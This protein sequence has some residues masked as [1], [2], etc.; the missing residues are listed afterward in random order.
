MGVFACVMFLCLLEIET[1]HI[2]SVSFAPVL[3]LTQD[4]DL[5]AKVQKS[6]RIQQ[7]T[8]IGTGAVMPATMISSNTHFKSKLLPAPVQV[9]DLDACQEQSGY[10]FSPTT[11][12]SRYV[13]SLTCVCMHQR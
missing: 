11:S 12:S 9:E 7:D 1:D 10:A 6:W 13:K 2:L 8:G 5:A 3:Q 4:R